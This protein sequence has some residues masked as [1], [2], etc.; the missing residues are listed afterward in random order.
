MSSTSSIQLSMCVVFLSPTSFLLF[1]LRTDSPSLFSFPHRSSSPS[2]ESRSEFTP[3]RCLSRFVPLPLPPPL[4]LRPDLF[5]P[6]FGFQNHVCDEHTDTLQLYWSD[7]DVITFLA[8]RE[9]CRSLPSSSR[10]A[11]LTFP[12]AF[13]FSSGGDDEHLNKVKKLGDHHAQL[14]VS[15]RA[16]DENALFDDDEDEEEAEEIVVKGRKLTQAEEKE[17]IQRSK[18][19]AKTAPVFQGLRTPAAGGHRIQDIRELMT[20]PVSRLAFIS[21]LLSR[22]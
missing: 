22:S 17:S 21:A 4:L 2:S 15:S 10:S 1:H 20:V 12:P 13:F 19:A 6:F 3:T 16:Q 18:S 9:P 7:R 14:E 5:H 11:S 8:E